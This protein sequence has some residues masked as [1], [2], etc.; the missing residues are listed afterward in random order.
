[1]DGAADAESYRLTENMRQIQVSGEIGMRVEYIGD[2]A[3]MLL[4]FRRKPSLESV[5]QKSQVR[6]LL[7]LDPTVEAFSVVYGAIAANKNRRQC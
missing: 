6:E 1:M 5:E 4:I 3:I 2:R 7:G